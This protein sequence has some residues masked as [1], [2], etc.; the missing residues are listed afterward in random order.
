MTR[1]LVT[2]ATGRTGSLVLKKLQALDSINVVGFARTPE[3]V[4]DLFGSTGQFYFGTIS[5]RDS[6]TPALKD[7]DVLVILTSAQ[8]QVTPP[9]GPGQPPGCT[10]EAGG[11]PEEVDYQGQ[12]HQIDAAKAAGV[13]HILLVGSMGGTNEQHPTQYLW[14]NPHLETKIRAISD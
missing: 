13:K 11:T 4:Q 12:L 8:P 9:P 14:Q 10:F 6:L 7:C 5:D 2:G 1:V 3:K